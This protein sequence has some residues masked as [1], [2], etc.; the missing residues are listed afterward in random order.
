MLTLLLLPLLLFLM[1]LWWTLLPLGNLFV[2]FINQI[3]LLS[4]REPYTLRVAH[5]FALHAL[6]DL[7]TS[8]VLLFNS[9]FVLVMFSEEMIKSTYEDLEFVRSMKCDFTKIG[10][11]LREAV[12]VV[13]DSNA[14]LCS[15]MIC[16]RW[17]KYSFATFRGIYF[18]FPCG[19]PLGCPYVLKAAHS[20]SKS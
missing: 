1:R 2:P 17:Y 13:Y 15:F 9:R 14:I 12:I 11:R 16:I 6:L 10:I 8:L 7:H 19:P 20:A 3:N 4:C 5:N 18:G